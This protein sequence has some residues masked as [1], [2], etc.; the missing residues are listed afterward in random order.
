MSIKLPEPIAAYFAATNA[1]NVEAMLVLFAETAFVKDEG[2]DR[3]G[4]AAIREWMEEAIKKYRFTVEVLGLT[5]ENGRQ[6]VTGHVS[7]NF[8]GSPVDLRHFFTLA[9][10]KITRLEII[11]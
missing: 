8:P 3:R 7:G 10:K 6:V 5:E 2:Q 1:H 9:G 11:P 4:L